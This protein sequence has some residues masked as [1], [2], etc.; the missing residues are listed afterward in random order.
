MDGWMVGA[1]IDRAVAGNSNNGSHVYIADRA[2]GCPSCC[3]PYAWPLPLQHVSAHPM[4]QGS[5]RGVSI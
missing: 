4:P 2:S 3:G 1:Q 5:E